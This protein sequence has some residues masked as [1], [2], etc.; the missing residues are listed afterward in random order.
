MIYKYRIKKNHG[1]PNHLLND[2]GWEIYPEG[3]YRLI[4]HVKN[5]W[6]K[7]VFITE[8]GVADKSDKY[9]AP[10]IVAHLQQIKR[11]IDDGADAVGYLH[12][13]LMDNY[14]WQEDYRPE[15]R[16]GL[17]RIDRN[18]SDGKQQQ[19]KQ[20]PDFTR[21]ITKG[22]EAFK[23]IVEESNNQSNGGVIANSAILKA[24]EKFGIITADGSNIT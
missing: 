6:N 13:S 2:L 8:N 10:F 24:K 16:F 12:W 4:M 19:L 22:A 5:Q 18:G 20:K 15:A 21:H 14:E 23:I 9:R 1:H 17:F 3:L 7:P 11:A